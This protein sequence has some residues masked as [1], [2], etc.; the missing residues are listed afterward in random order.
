MMLLAEALMS[1][2]LSWERDQLGSLPQNFLSDRIS[3]VLL[4]ICNRTLLGQDSDGSWGPPEVTAYAVLTLL[5]LSSLPHVRLLEMEIA[6]AIKTGRQSLSQSQ[7]R[8]AE[9][10]YVWIGKV[11]FG[12]PVISQ[13]YCLAAMSALPRPYSSRPTRLV[14]P[15]SEAVEKKSQVLSRLPMFMKVPYWKVKASVI[16]AYSLLPGLKRTQENIFSHRSKVD[17]AYPDYI[18][19]IWI[20]INNCMPHFL[21]TNLVCE[22][23]LCSLLCTLA[24]GY[25]ESIIAQLPQ[26]TLDTVEEII[27]CICEKP[28]AEMDGRQK[29]PGAEGDNSEEHKAISVAFNGGKIPESDSEKQQGKSSGTSPK[30]FNIADEITIV[31]SIKISLDRWAKYFLWHPQVRRSSPYDQEILRYELHAQIQ[32]NLT[33]IRDSKQLSQQFGSTRFLNPRTSFYRWVYTDGADN[34]FYPFMWAFHNC[35]VGGRSSSGEKDCFPT[36]RAK[37]FAKDLCTHL[38]VMTRLYND[39]S[40]VGRDHAEQNLNSVD[41]PEFHAPD[42]FPARQNSAHGSA[43]AAIGLRNT[44]STHEDPNQEAEEQEERERKSHV[45]ALA[46]YEQQCATFA[47]DHLMTEMRNKDN[48]ER[49]KWA[50]QAV[51]L[52]VDLTQCYGELCTAR[53]SSP[54]VK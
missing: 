48:G 21:N 3:V 17:K 32:S 2:L 45:L 8:W 35:L 46:R 29:W 1:L 14:T 16:E 7:D 36:A 50:R 25:M 9:A 51:N 49:G 18:P 38:A 30:M 53:D 26:A 19:C 42:S 6:S 37:Y 20:V 33:Q 22:M 11:T 43:D 15:S 39:Y 24:D 5:T 41:F 47:K 27:R 54:R 13:A 12:V 10:H 40:S 28:N 23:V 31:S 34:S 44:S 52:F 4:Q